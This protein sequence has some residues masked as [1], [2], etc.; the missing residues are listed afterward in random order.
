MRSVVYELEIY[1]PHS[2]KDIWR[3]FEASTPF[4]SFSKGDLI[5]PSEWSGSQSPLKVMRVTEVQHV[6]RERD[7]EARH[8][9]MLYTE[10]ATIFEAPTE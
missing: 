1:S 9:I 5:E 6:L 10:E 4:M 8:K 7:E 2:R 3:S